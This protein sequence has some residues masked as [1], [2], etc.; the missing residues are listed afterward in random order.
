LTGVLSAQSINIVEALSC[1]T[2][3][4]FLLERDDLNAAIS[5]LTKALQ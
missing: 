1:Y 2:D 5:V 3:T 4:I